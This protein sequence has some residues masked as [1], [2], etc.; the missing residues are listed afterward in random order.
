MDK[1]ELQ[2]RLLSEFANRRNRAKEIAEINYRR[3]LQ[4]EEFKMIEDKISNLIVDIA[5]AEFNGKDVY[6]LKEQQTMLESKRETILLKNKM[7]SADL[8]P[9]YKCKHC[10]DTGFLN[11]EYCSCFKQEYVDAIMYNSNINVKAFTSLEDYKIDIFEDASKAEVKKLKEKLVTYTHKFP[12]T[13]VKNITLMGK[14]GVGKSFLSQAVAKSIINKGY[15]AFYTTAFNFNNELLKYH[16]TFSED[17]ASIIASYLEADLLII[18]DLGT[19]PIFRN[20]TLEYLVLILNERLNKGKHTFVTTNLDLN[21]FVDRY[22][23]RI[24]SRLFNKA[25]SLTINMKG[26]DL[27][28]KK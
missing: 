24:F 11:G 9:K 6:A 16:T 4:I 27:R 5:K 14:T 21:H 1:R 8:L 2:K 3:A 20:V 7:S 12:N 18:D 26:K 28:L 23:E 10:K 25:N 19:E 22:G 13:K 15:T 17:K